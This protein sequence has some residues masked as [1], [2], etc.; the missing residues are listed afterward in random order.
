MQKLSELPPLAIITLGVTLAIT[1][2]ARKFDS[3]ADAATSS[4]KAANAAT[5]AA[6]IVYPTA[7]NRPSAAGEALNASLIEMNLINREM[8]RIDNL[9]PIELIEVVRR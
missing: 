2:G 5:V 1:W 8:S 7:L 3:T 6:V 9:L 4:E